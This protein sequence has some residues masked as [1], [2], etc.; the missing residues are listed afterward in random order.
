[1]IVLLQRT[2]LIE[3]RRSIRQCHHR[4]LPVFLPRRGRPSPTACGKNAINLKA[5]VRSC[6]KDV[7]PLHQVFSNNGG[8]ENGGKK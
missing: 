5:G 6:E 8:N 7:L 4:F 1:M 2:T 3:C